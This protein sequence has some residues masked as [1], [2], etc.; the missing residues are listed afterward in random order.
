MVTLLAMLAVVA[1][2]GLRRTRF[3]LVSFGLVTALVLG[4]VVAQHLEVIYGELRVQ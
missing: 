1:I 2:I 3:D 4:V